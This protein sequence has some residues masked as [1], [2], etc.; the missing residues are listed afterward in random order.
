MLKVLTAD[1]TYEAATAV[2]NIHETVL[3]KFL[4]RR[5][6]PFDFLSRNIMTTSCF[7]QTIV[8]LM[9]CR[10]IRRDHH[11]KEK[12]SDK[13]VTKPRASLSRVSQTVSQAVSQTVWS[14]HTTV[15]V[16][17][18]CTQEYGE[19][20]HSDVQ[21]VITLRGWLFSLTFRGVTF[22]L[23]RSKLLF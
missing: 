6:M 14:S 12:K 2:Q 20:C 19:Y 18:T 23:F 22:L 10:S 11:R 1:D 9:K 15:C 7:I 8:S 16:L 21:T 13:E 4:C 3:S 5:D 17:M